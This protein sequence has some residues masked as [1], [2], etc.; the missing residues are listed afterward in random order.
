MG[1]GHDHRT[2]DLG[3]KRLTAAVGINVLLTVA[4]ILGGV[5]SGSLSLIA[6]ALH[7][8]S[9]AASL[10]I[11]L[12]AR[13]I[14]RKPPDA[15][16]TF[17]Y[18]RAEI[19]AALINLTTLIIIGL[20]LIYEALW[21]FA[22]PKEIEGRTVVIIAGIALAVDI[23]TAVLTYAMSKESI[24]VKA[25]FLHNV[26][27]ALASVGVIIAG[28]L[29][30][31][32]DWYRVDAVITLMIAGYVLWQGGTMLPKTVHILMEGTPDHLSLPDVIAAMENV[33]GVAG[34]HHVHIW[35]L[36]ERRNALEAHIISEQTQPKETES[37]KDALKKLL[38]EKF[39]IGHSTLEFEYPGLST[40][41]EN[42]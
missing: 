19:I 14:G 5:F 12:F 41:K 39:D 15:F 27:D 28:T 18:K 36:D 23:V 35:R 8:L 9:D 1:H 22:E 6:D 38:A 33:A 11:A 21:R 10:V 20:Y 16:K 34:V 37:I 17:G 31:L 26:S 29:I 25:A 4:Q 13:K 2:E 32:Y 42:S 24:N 3:D 40:C 7:N 30:L